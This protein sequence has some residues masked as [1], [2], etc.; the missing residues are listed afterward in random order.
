[1]TIATFGLTMRTGWA[2]AIAV[3]AAAATG[4]AAA[5]ARGPA[6]LRFEPPFARVPAVPGGPEYID[7][8]RTDAAGDVFVLV[9]ARVSTFTATGAPIATW[10]LPGATSPF[11]HV[12]ADVSPDGVLYVALQGG[13][14]VRAYDRTGTLV[15]SWGGV[16]GAFALAVDPRGSVLV[17]DQEGLESLHGPKRFTP[18][19]RFLGAPPGYVVGLPLAVAADGTR[20]TENG[21][22]VSGTRADGRPL[23]WVGRDCTYSHV[24]PRT[25]PT[26]PGGT[27]GIHDIVGGP[28]GGFAI[29]QTSVGRLSVFDGRGRPRISCRGPHV[30]RPI[31][32]VDYDPRGGGLVVAERLALRRARYIATPGRWCDGLGLRIE[33]VSASAEPRHP[34]SWRI[35]YRLTAPARVRL[36][37]VGADARPCQTTAADGYDPHDGCSF[38][39]VTRS[40]AVPGGRGTHTVHLRPAQPGRSFQ[41]V[42]VGRRDSAGFN[43]PYVPLGG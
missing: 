19:G 10:Q 30:M 11:D 2:V 18:D 9:G 23:T 37:V 15:Q 4:P 5:Q 1:M 43:T 26:G 28:R 31:S 29:A 27:D 41:L 35:R 13:D 16:E 7:T 36:D 8:L 24:D 39:T 25:C 20:W 3:V 14:A 38:A 6:G 21:E 34:G 42:A 32:S 12:T 17:D 40:K 33:S 22:G